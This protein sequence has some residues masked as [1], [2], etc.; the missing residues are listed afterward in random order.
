M[1]CLRPVELWLPG[2][3]GGSAWPA[4]VGSDVGACPAAGVVLAWLRPLTPGLAGL[5]WVGVELVG[6]LMGVTSLMAWDRAF[7]TGAGRAPAAPA[8]V[9]AP[10]ATATVSP[11]LVAALAMPT[12][13]N[14]AVRNVDV[15]TMGR[16]HFGS[17]DASR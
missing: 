2:L 5:P 16:L 15:A 8:A 7:C 11:A 14:M 9:S 13:V 12:L 3:V 17:P 4:G 6:R 1:A 10:A